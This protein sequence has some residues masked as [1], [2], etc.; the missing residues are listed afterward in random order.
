MS[1]SKW[2]PCDFEQCHPLL[3]SGGILV[4]HWST[5]SSLSSF[6]SY[7]CKAHCIGLELYACTHWGHNKIATTFADVSNVIKLSIRLSVR[8]SVHPACRFCSLTLKFLD[9]FFSYYTQII[10]SM[11]G[12]VACN[13]LWPWPVS[14]RLCCWDIA[15][16]MDYCP[17]FW[18]GFDGVCAFNIVMGIFVLL[19]V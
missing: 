17:M 1:L 3:W 6:C 8:L 13:D 19:R 11:R 14:P 15:Y 12:C 4:D 9:G 5:I 2:L 10:T 18:G 7:A 16:F